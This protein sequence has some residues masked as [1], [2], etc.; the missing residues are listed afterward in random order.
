[1]TT[2]I[3]E[4]F[5]F[6]EFRQD[7]STTN[8]RK[9]LRWASCELYVAFLR[10]TSGYKE[11]AVMHVG[12]QR[13]FIM[14]TSINALQTLMASAE[15]E[16]GHEIT[17]E[18][19]SLAELARNA[20]LYH[21]NLHLIDKEE[22]LHIGL[23]VM[24]LLG[25]TA[26][27][28]DAEGNEVIYEA[29]PFSFE[30]VND[31]GALPYGAVQ[32]WHDIELEYTSDRDLSKIKSIYVFDDELDWNN[33]LFPQLPDDAKAVSTLL[34]SAQAFFERMKVQ[35][36]PIW[37]DESAT[38]TDTESCYQNSL[39]GADN[40]STFSPLRAMVDQDIVPA[41]ADIT[42]TITT[43]AR[44]DDDPADSPE[45]WEIRVSFTMPTGANAVFIPDW[46]EASLCKANTELPSTTGSHRASELLRER[47]V[48][49]LAWSFFQRSRDFTQ[50][51]FDTDLKGLLPDFISNSYDSF[52][53]DYSD[54]RFPC[55]ARFQCG[56]YGVP[57][58]LLGQDQGNYICM[59][60][61][62][63]EIPEA[64]VSTLVPRRS[65]LIC[66]ESKCMQL[67]AFFD[68]LAIPTSLIDFPD[69]WYKGIRISNKDIKDKFYSEMSFR[70]LPER[71]LP[72]NVN[73]QFSD[74]SSPL[75]WLLGCCAVVAL[76]VILDMVL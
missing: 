76:F 12:S 54:K 44:H 52:Q 57:M 34:P 3:S 8:K 64:D 29:A 55:L 16:E 10:Y 21:L 22:S 23:S 18:Q 2:A 28:E 38:P 30:S 50:S 31:T 32:Y 60:L 70:K 56:E 51:L 71:K 35:P 61:T 25:M 5:S 39:L 9:L 6:T 37:V 46:I 43:S 20:H 69:H 19:M 48:N 58:L 53:P 40:L 63:E 66:I 45:C 68:K 26:I 4:P 14:S 41:A 17:V 36:I 74:N 49:Q 15:F 47:I 13:R 27:L 62:F 11:P 7:L 67:S 73:Q 75:M 24:Q 65:E 72:E 1:M 59:P 42:L 33:P